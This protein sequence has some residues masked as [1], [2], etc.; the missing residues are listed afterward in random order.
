V[1]FALSVLAACRRGEPSTY[2]GYVE[3]EFVHVASPVGGRLERLAVQRGQIVAAGAPLFTLEAEQESAAKREAEGQLRAA[4]AHLS[5]LTTGQ[6]PQEL[7]VAKAELAQAVTSEKQA[8]LQLGRREV[9]FGAGVIPRE[10]VD[11]ARSAHEVAA[12]RV[13]ELASRL[14]VARLPSR[15]DEIREQTAE[16]EAERAAVAQE[17]WRLGQKQVA[18]TQAG[19]VADTLYREGEWVPAGS[20]VV[21][22]L[23]PA[24]VKLRFFVPESVA[25]GLAPGRKVTVRC[26]GCKAD[27]EATVSFIAAEPEYT[28]PIIY[29]KETRAKL[30]FLVEARPAL[31]HAPELRPGQPVTV[32]LR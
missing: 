6:R 27:V 1:L 30:V 7:D 29:S 22:I 25:G 14:K 13:E 20:P 28:P 8:A 31:E 17:D 21:R 16:V 19:L 4:E 2:Q 26:D 24:N 9:Q 12:A 23:P 3:G 10:Q 15:R 5:D 18:A 11:D 32:A